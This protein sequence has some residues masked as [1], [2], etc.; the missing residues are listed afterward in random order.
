MPTASSTWASCERCG[1]QLGRVLRDGQGVQVD[2]AEERVGLVLIGDP[3]PERAE[4]VAELDG[5]GRLDAG[6]DAG[7][8]GRSY[9]GRRSSG[10]MGSAAGIRVVSSG[11]VESTSDRPQ[12]SRMPLV[13]RPISPSPA[14][15][16]DCGTANPTSS[17][18]AVGVAQPGDGVAEARRLGVGEVTEAAGRARHHGVD[19]R[20]DLDAAVLDHAERVE[21]A[22]I[23][24]LVR[25]EGPG[26][27]RVVAGTP[28][29]GRPAAPA[30][31][32]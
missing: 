20:L 12:V 18:H 24:L 16:I 5:T 17:V 8:G 2:H 31:K 19:E 29:R 3:V 7:H 10:P 15:P 4:Q 6:E 26:G 14:S 22:P 11:P 13:I 9:S 21:V 30:S 27:L 28:A 25:G 32:S 23:G 1:A